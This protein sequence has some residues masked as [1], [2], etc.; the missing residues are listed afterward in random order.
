[1]RRH[2]G[3]PAPRTR[4]RWWG[5]L[6]AAILVAAALQAGPA[7]AR[8]PAQVG[9][10]SSAHQKHAAIEAGRRAA[11]PR[12]AQGALVDGQHRL[13]F[14]AGDDWEPSID[15]L[16]S[17]VYAIWT[18]FP[19]PGTFPRKRIMI[20][21]SHDSGATWGARHVVSDSPLG[22]PYTDQ[23]D[24]VVAVDLNGDVYVSFLAWGYH[25]ND[26][27]HV[28][29]ARSRDHGVTVPLVRQV[30]EDFCNPGLEGC[31][32][33]WIAVRGGHVYVGYAN[34]DSRM[35]ISSSHDSGNSWTERVAR[36][37]D[38]VVFA[39]GAAVDATGRIYFAWDICTDDDCLGPVKMIVSHSDDRGV[40]WRHRLVATVPDSPLCPYVDCGFGFFSA[41]I[42]L[43]V[44]PNGTAVAIYSRPG[45]PGAYPEA[46]AQRSVDGGETWTNPEL[47]GPAGA[48]DSRQLFPAIVAT[49]PG[50]FAVTWMDD[51]KGSPQH[52][53]NGW[54][55]FAARTRDG[56]LS[57]QDERRVSVVASEGQWRDN[58]FLFPYGDYQD[59]TVSNG[60]VLAIWGAGY[61]YVGPGNTYER[62]VP[63]RP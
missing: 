2:D 49:G 16:G 59:L 55:V 39:G 47:V 48:Y 51:R 25:G 37:A 58:G 33:E 32:K 26:K 56:G 54:N 22:L 17:D 41:Q 63:F 42:A 57:W 50:R 31:D 44:D 7:V 21:V 60:R 14:E 45:A 36:D 19:A 53:T 11:A 12:S 34:A 30:D 40:T 61:D 6:G 18:H 3:H 27:S 13:G 35:Y 9:H 5:A 10:G 29:V 28:F 52:G 4:S 38:N 23:A 62:R 24:P 8:Q 20:Q 15:A 1:M 46:V 43:D